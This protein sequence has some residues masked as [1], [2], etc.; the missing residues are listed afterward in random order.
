MTFLKDLLRNLLILGAIILVMFI[1]YP[2]IM[3]QV[4]QVY[5]ALFGP[6]AI[7]ML[8]V[9]ALPRPRRKK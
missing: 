5:G 2:D 9:F 3:K 1:I 7:I 8:I 6:L 4:F